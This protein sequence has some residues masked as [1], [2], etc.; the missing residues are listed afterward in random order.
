[1]CR[2]ILSERSRRQDAALAGLAP[3]QGPR[4]G[5]PGN[6]YGLKGPWGPAVSPGAAV[7]RAARATSFWEA[8]IPPGLCVGVERAVCPGKVWGRPQTDLEVVPHP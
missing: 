1:M 6:E 2:L 8:S 3:F 5:G 4:E 7:I